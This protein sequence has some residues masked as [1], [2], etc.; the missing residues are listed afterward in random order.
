MRNHTLIT[1]LAEARGGDAHVTLIDPG[2]N[3]VIIMSSG[4]M[5]GAPSAVCTRVQIKLYNISI[6]NIKFLMK[7]LNFFFEKF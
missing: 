5:V 7:N 4:G 3:V 6:K 1:P 2:S